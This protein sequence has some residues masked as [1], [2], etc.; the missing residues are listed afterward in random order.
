MT[1]FL[2]FLGFVLLI[3]GA[4][5]LIEGSTSIGKRFGV[6]EMLIGLT[7]VAMGTSLP[8]L[9][10]NVFASIYGETDLAISNVLGSNIINILVIIGLTAI[11]KPVLISPATTNRDIPVSLMATILLGIMVQDSVFSAGKPNELGFINGILLLVIMGI[12]LY[13]SFSYRQKEP[14]DAPV[15]GIIKPL[16]IAIFYILAG[17]TGLYFG[18]TWIVDGVTEISVL[19]GMDQSEVGLTIVAAATSLPEL[20]TSI[21]ASIK[22]NNDIAVGNAIGSCIFNILLILGVSSVIH[23]LP[24]DSSSLGDLVTVLLANLLMF[25]FIFT[26]KGRQISRMEGI[27]M[28]VVYVGFIWFRFGG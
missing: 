4:N 19:L 28:L 18:G 25:I 16:W 7:I 5:L 21:I 11:I 6:S 14:P 12:F 2:F 17:L 26:G 13:F 15:T 1:I 22:K 9:I 20:A 10:I 27:L 23:P 8:E 3:L 24:F